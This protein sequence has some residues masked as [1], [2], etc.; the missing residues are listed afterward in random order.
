MN[1]ASVVGHV[2]VL[3]RTP[4]PGERS[5]LSNRGEEEERRRRRRSVQ[6]GAEVTHVDI[7][8]LTLVA[9]PFRREKTKTI[10]PGVQDTPVSVCSATSCC[11]NNAH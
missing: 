7:V 3:V 9:A 6:Q 11:N 8:T 1:S 10:Q 5:L 2:P 4:L